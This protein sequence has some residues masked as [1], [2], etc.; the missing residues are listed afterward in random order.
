MSL[1]PPFPFAATFVSS[2]SPSVEAA[3]KLNPRT[4]FFQ[5]VDIMLRSP[6][7]DTTTPELDLTKAGP[8]E[9]IRHFLLDCARM[10]LEAPRSIKIILATSEG[11]VGRGGLFERRMVDCDFVERAE[12]MLSF[13]EKTT[14]PNLSVPLRFETILSSAV[15]AVLLQPSTSDSYANRLS[16]IETE[17][18][19]R[20]SLPW[21]F[22]DPIPHRNIVLI[23][24][25]S[26]LQ[27][28]VGFIQAVKDLNV[29]V[30]VLGTGEPQG[31]K[32]WLQN[33]D[34]SPG[35]CDAFI[36][37][38]MTIDDGLPGRIV[39]AVR[40]Y[41]GFAEIH[42]ILTGHDRYLVP[43][44]KAAVI[45][46]LPASPVRAHEI[47]TDKYAMRQFE[48]ESQ[49]TDFQF[50][51]FANLGEIQERVVHAE[52]PVAIRYPAIVKPVSGYLSEGVA[53]VSNDAELVASVGRVDTKRHGHA[54]IVETYIDGPEFDA[55][56]ILCEGEILFFELVDDF[57][58]A[59]DRTGAGMEGTFFETSEF[60]PSALP[61]AER[62]T[63]RCSLHETLLALGFTWGLFHVEGRVKDSA[64]EFRA[65]ASGIVDLRPRLDPRPP[66]QTPAC[67]LVEINAR[68]PGLGCAMSTLH[69]YGV[70]FYAAHLLACLRDAR[71]LRLVSTPFAFNPDGAQY[72]CEVVFIQ[73]RRG[74]RVASPDPCGELLRRRPDLGAHVSRCACC[75][76]LGGVVPDPA[77]GV[78]LLLAYF[79]VYSRR[80][81]QEVRE[82]AEMIRAEF[83][84]DIV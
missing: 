79:L 19:S 55:N 83:R 38:D 39:A 30:I 3:W 42:G 48:V 41:T 66:T 26:Y 8:P 69:T 75:Y 4:E 16:S 43:T 35:F 81:R 58:S 76:A 32:H 52:H 53:R 61:A 25:Y 27:T 50:L 73:P 44:A 36:P 63:V 47:A 12:E 34:N 2:G 80:A 20:L 46:G 67:F 78:C 40:G 24:G 9:K 21:L 64:M 82:V 7:A 17:L 54:V 28:G 22:P 84:C 15:G 29:S 5:T 65:D 37:I 6:A 60:T 31:P 13:G 62:A 72:H 1:A 74:G 57:P 18:N 56:I 23:E 10:A 77:T 33:S 14:P 71:R 11:F 59:G 51:R 70:D 68:I 49:R 45:L